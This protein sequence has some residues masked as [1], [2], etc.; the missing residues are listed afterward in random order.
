MER[1]ALLNSRE[2]IRSVAK[3]LASSLAFTQERAGRVSVVTPVIYP[4]GARVVLTIEPSPGGYFVSDLGSAFREADIMNGASIFTRI[5]RQTAAKFDIRFDSEMFFE[6]EIPEDSLVAAALA[7]SNASRHAVEQVAES[8]SEKRADQQ[9]DV[10]WQ[11][12][13][14]AF[15]PERVEKDVEYRGAS[16]NWK[17]DALVSL[18]GGRRGLFELVQPSPVSVNS[19][20]SKFLDVSDLD[21]RNTQLNAVVTD[22]DKTAHLTLLGSRANVI[23]INAATELYL[24]AA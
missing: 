21:D 1:S 24:T 5:A 19:A 17:F 9:R 7:V 12:L 4:G 23:P 22:R 16:A 18:D 14:R 6:L 2:D 15:R 8:L 10:L 13:E 3:E 20:I 11:K